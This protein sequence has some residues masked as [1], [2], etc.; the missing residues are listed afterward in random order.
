MA[1]RAETPHLLG[2]GGRLLV[3][4]A[5]ADSVCPSNL[6]VKGALA[7]RALAT[8]E[9]IGVP[10]EHGGRDPDEVRHRPMIPK[11]MCD[12]FRHR[13]GGGETPSGCREVD[14]A[15]PE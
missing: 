2:L 15:A 1:E 9:A 7:D 13:I 5:P 4:T 8:Q 11:R 3:Q 12:P 6:T 10:R 14:E